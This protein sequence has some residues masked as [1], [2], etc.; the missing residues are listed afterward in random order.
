[1]L[2]IFP[3]KTYLG[4]MVKPLVTLK[5]HTVYKNSIVL[6]SFSGLVLLLLI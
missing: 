4:N 6:C 1:M 2:I 3:E 5:L